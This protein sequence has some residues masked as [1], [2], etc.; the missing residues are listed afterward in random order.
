[1]LNK[2][3][4]HHPMSLVELVVDLQSKVVCELKDVETLWIMGLCAVIV[5]YLWSSD[6]CCVYVYHARCN[7]STGKAE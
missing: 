4:V 1:M 2:V 5:C 3:P 6:V 7:R